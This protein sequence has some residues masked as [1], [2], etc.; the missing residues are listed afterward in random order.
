MAERTRVLVTD[1]GA[2]DKFG[3]VEE[4]VEAYDGELIYGDYDSED[5][6]LNSDLDAD[7]YLVSKAPITRQVIEN[8]GSAICIIRTG[9]GYDNINVKAA[10]DHGL[11]V[12]NNPG[13]RVAQSLSEHAIGLMLA[14]A[15]EMVY[16]DREMRDDN[17]WGLGKGWPVRP[18]YD[19]CFGIVG[20]GRV[21]RAAADK[22]KGLG[23]DV[24]A[25]DPYLPDDL[26]EKFG[27]ERVGFD[28][29]LNRAD[30]ISVH[31]PL[32]AETHYMFG[33]DEFNKMS[34]NAVFVNTARGPIVDNEALV[35]A[36]EGSEIYAAGLDNFE[37]EPPV[38]SPVLKCDRIVCSPHHGSAASSTYV[39]KANE[40]KNEVERALSGEHLRNVVNPEVFKYSDSLM[41][42]EYDSW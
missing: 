2:F 37:V 20:L 35:E 7:I 30:C 14:A 28:E 1:I 34:E 13:N 10:T 32:T 24:I 23:M 22:A 15:R 21:G 19:G 18:M 9:V 36:V 6:L 8:I 12:S 42:P 33:E 4:I 11:P 5:D 40:L 16:C 39:E 31:T 17:G 41:N 27:V 25:Y 29:I 26:F 3:P 38:D